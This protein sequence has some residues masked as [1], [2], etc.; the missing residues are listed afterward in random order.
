MKWLAFFSSPSVYAQYVNITGIS[1]SQ[2]GGTF[3][4]FSASVMGKWFGKGVN[5]NVF[6]PVLS[7]PTATTTRRRTGPICS[8]RSS[9]AR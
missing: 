5:R 1:P 2:S 3:N 6:Y 8:S 4:G 9:R 7:R